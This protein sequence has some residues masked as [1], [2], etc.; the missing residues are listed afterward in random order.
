MAAPNILNATSIV[1]ISTV[2]VAT[3]ST[4]NIVTCPAN[5]LIKITSMFATNT[6]SGAENIDI[7]LKKNGVHCEKPLFGMD[8]AHPT[9]AGET[10]P[11]ARTQQY[12]AGWYMEEN[13][14]L[15]VVC[16]AGSVMS[17]LG[18]VTVCV[19]YDLIDDA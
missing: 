7:R 1:G 2:L 17:F 14:V 9:T 15:Q 5:K 11:G 10:F 12:P 18:A 16:G 8:A 4:Q 19:S 3:A 6:H 13:D